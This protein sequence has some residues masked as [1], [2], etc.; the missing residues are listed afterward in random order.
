MFIFFLRN[1]KSSKYLCA[2]QEEC[3]V[4]EMPP[5]TDSAS[6]AKYNAARVS[7]WMLSEEPLGIESTRILIN[8]RVSELKPRD[9]N[10]REGTSEER[11]RKNGRQ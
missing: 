5:R 1:V 10:I 9:G 6:K 8:F 7:L 11:T 3:C 4:C 2:G